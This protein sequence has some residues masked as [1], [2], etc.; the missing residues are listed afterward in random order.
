MPDQSK[1]ILANTLSGVF[2]PLLLPIYLA[3]GLL[4]LPQFAPAIPPRLKWQAISIVA[5]TFV[6]MP[7][8]ILY[9]LAKW[10]KIQSIQLNEQKERFFPMLLIA[11]S[12]VIGLRLLHV[13][14][15]PAALILLMRGV[16]LA[17]MIVALIS[18]IWK[19]SAHTTAIGGALGIILLLSIIYKIDLSGL[20][21]FIT[22]FS[23]AI[24]WARL[25]LKRHTIKQVNYGF[26]AGFSTM[27]LSFLLHTIL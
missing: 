5:Y 10:K 15:A 17:I 9:F 14:D 1:Q 26:L 19:I 6:I 13:F 8:S 12:Y 27:I 22:L 20:A 21:I 4:F 11:I 2:H 23:G 7:V 16:C 25:Y 18:I 24:G 3:L